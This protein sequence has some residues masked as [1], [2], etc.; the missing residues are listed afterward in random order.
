M[1]DGGAFQ[2]FY[3][4][5]KSNAKDAEK[6]MKSLQKTSDETEKSIKKSKEGAVEL[7]KAFTSVVES[8]AAA[9]AAYLSFT[10]IKTGI[11]NAEQFNRTL[12]TQAKLWG[13]NANEMAAFAEMAKSAGGSEQGA[14]GF[15]GGLI[16]Q[17]AGIRNT[18]SPIALME[19]VRAMVKGLSDTQA[20]LKF[21]QIGMGD[22]GLQKT[23]RESAADWERDKAKYQQLSDLMEKLGPTTQAFGTAWDDL[24][25]ASRRFWLS[26]SQ[27]ILPALTMLF[28]GLSELLT[29]A[30]DNKWVAGGLTVFLATLSTLFGGMAILKI[31]TGFGA[32]ATAAWS[33]L[34]A[35]AAIAAALST[36][37][38]GVAALGGG[39][40]A[41]YYG[42]KGLGE[43]IIGSGSTDIPGGKV[44]S[45]DLMNYLIGTKK[46]P[47]I[48]AAA[49]VANIM[50]ESGGK[51]NA[52]G[53]NGQ[54]IG[55]FQMHPARRA[56]ILAGTGID[57]TK[58]DWRKQIDGGLYDL[59][60]RPE[61]G[62]FMNATNT[63]D[64][65]SIF[66][67]RF[68]S[69]AGG[70]SE[71][72]RRGNSAMQIMAGTPFGSM[73]SSAGGDK[74]ITINGIN[75]HTQATDAPGIAAAIGSEMQ[76]HIT[77]IFSQNAD[78]VAY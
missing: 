76:R 16:Q 43:R 14:L 6:D 52:V 73:S 1:A 34:P 29:L 38:L 7:G 58:P 61:Y 71:A 60:T 19:Q 41:G 72:M 48:Q 47:P 9:S 62:A 33:A 35:L 26:A 24:T 11:V 28:E 44:G 78:A 27:V 2:T 10:A 18:L 23:A 22:I 3:L 75:I 54:A 12:T 53:D 55:L 57:M 77:N 21:K 15:F 64:A 37:V 68:E 63:Y 50:A 65:A 66:S 13:Q 20:Q 5:F 70:I 56:K 69:P 4:M 32:I 31:V 46:I 40:A 39:A 25:F 67:Q 51:F 36:V 59:A 45:A 74:I 30:G 42:I 17:N 49:I 8:A